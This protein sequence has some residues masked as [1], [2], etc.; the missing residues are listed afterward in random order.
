MNS[1]CRLL[2]AALMV[3]SIFPCSIDTRPSFLP[4]HVPEK[5]D[6]AFVRGELGIIPS[7]L[8]ERYKLIAWRY[9]AGLPLDQQE[10]EAILVRPTGDNSFEPEAW[11]KVRQSAGLTNRFFNTGT[12]SRLEPGT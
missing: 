2:A 11:G 6:S 4:Q 3:A 7:T 9:L 8:S 10:Q 12:A 5:F 1:G